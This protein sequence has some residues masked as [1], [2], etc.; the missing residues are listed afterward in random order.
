[1]D[2]MT[3]L[4][5]A[6]KSLEVVKALRDI[7]KQIG[8]AELKARAADLLSNLADLKVALVDARDEI[9]E[10]D[11][12]IGRL[13]ATF[14]L[15]A[16]AVRSGIFLYDKKADG[17]PKGQPYCTRC[18]QIDGVMIKLGQ[19]AGIRGDFICPQCK[20]KYHYVQVY[21]DS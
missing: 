17:S 8:Q 2:I 4:S 3:A 7:D 10:K 5:T 11:K 1:M 20:T 21:P 15:K 18:E 14:Q 13:K 6:T 9:E 16:D 19:D 12:E